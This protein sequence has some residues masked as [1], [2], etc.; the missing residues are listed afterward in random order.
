MS[1][2]C[3]MGGRPGSS[4]VSIQLPGGDDSHMLQPERRAERAVAGAVH[5]RVQ[6]EGPECCLAIGPKTVSPQASTL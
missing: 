5:G 3:L 2:Y 6:E 1:W 4:R